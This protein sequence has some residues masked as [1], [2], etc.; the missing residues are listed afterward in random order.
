[1]RFFKI[2]GTA[3]ALCKLASQST[4]FKN[5][6]ILEKNTKTVSHAGAKYGNG[7]LNGNQ[8]DGYYRRSSDDETEMKIEKRNLRISM[9]SDDIGDIDDYLVS[10]KKNTT[11]NNNNNNLNEDINNLTISSKSNI[12]IKNNDKDIIINSPN[13]RL[14]LALYEYMA[15]GT[16]MSLQAVDT[17]VSCCLNDFKDIMDYQHAF[18]EYIIN[19]AANDPKFNK[20]K[21]TLLKNENQRIK[22]EKNSDDRDAISEDWEEE[23]DENPPVLPADQYERTECPETVRTIINILITS[24]RFYRRAG[25]CNRNLFFI[26]ILSHYLLW[27]IELSDFILF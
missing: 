4:P 19:T 11:N 13:A 26:V 15:I 2:I 20:N 22:N 5:I 24:S 16:S 12:I 27:K 17:I 25:K 10:E 21:Q 3:A 8:N 23:A 6:S 14:T 9:P 7:N 18:R 1:M